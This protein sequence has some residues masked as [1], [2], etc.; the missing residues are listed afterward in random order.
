MENLGYS[1]Q[2][3]LRKSILACIYEIS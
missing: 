2:K 3:K 1:G